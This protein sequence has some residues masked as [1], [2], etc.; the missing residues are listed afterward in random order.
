[1]YCWS[2]SSRASSPSSKCS[3][4]WPMPEVGFCKNSALMPIL[5]RGSATSLGCDHLV[6]AEQLFGG[7]PPRILAGALLSLANEPR[8]QIAVEQAQLERAGER[9]DVRRVDQ[10]RCPFRNLG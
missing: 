5:I 8:P 10:Q 9:L 1:M 3:R 7:A 4:C 2:L 6:D